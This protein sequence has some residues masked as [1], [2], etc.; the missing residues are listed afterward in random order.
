M[1]PD[2]STQKQAQSTTVFSISWE[3][4][5]SYIFPPF[6]LIAK[7]LN[8]IKE[9]NVK[10][11]YISSS[12]LAY[13]NMVLNINFSVDLVSLL[14]CLVTDCHI[15]EKCTQRQ[16]VQYQIPSSLHHPG[17]N[18]LM[19]NI[20][21]VGKKLILWCN[22]WKVNSFRLSE[23][24]ILCFLFSLL[25]KHLSYSVVNTHNVTLFQA[26]PFFF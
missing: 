14:D 16:I 1:S 6:R 11:G 25:R 10:K 22:Q 9:D 3:D 13:S 8:K 5:G 7:V 4:F 17:E 23:V 24:N 18:K 2:H 19:N 15:Q 20:N 12:I 21:Y 26:L